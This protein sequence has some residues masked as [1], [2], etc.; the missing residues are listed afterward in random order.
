MLGW[1]IFIHA[2]SMIFRNI[3]MA[4]RIFSVPLIAM[5]AVLL[6]STVFVQS[7]GQF[8]MIFVVLIAAIVL[9]IWGVVAWHRYILLEER[10]AGLIP[11]FNFRL[12]AGYFWRGVLLGFVAIP[13]L[14]VLAFAGSII[15]GAG[16]LEADT[17]VANLTSSTSSILVFQVFTW[18]ITL[19]LLVVLMRL[20][21][22]LPAYAL[23]RTIGL[24][25]SWEETQGATFSI[26]VLVTCLSI[27]QWLFDYS[28]QI[29]ADQQLIGALWQLATS[30]F[31]ALLNVSI[32]TTLY[33]VF[34]EKRELA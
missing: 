30:L 27:L 21:L 4:L 6:V 17:S 32:L 12:I 13:F 9:M 10:P 11:A 14:M 19:I 22:I 7:L 3:S 20:S 2:A 31:L 25:E 16:G 8:S 15:L 5:V 1:K 18:A 23:D 29:I 26:F 34:I 33:G 28:Y 24:A